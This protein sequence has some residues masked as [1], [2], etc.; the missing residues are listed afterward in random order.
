MNKQKLKK[1]VCQEVDKLEPILIKLAD[2][3]HENPEIS[4]REFKAMQYLQ[5]LLKEFNFLFTPIIK[6][7][8][9]TAFMAQKGIGKKKIGF[10]A[11]YDALPNLGHACGHNL[12]S[13][14]SVG[15]A[16]A[17]N[18]VTDNLAQTILFGCPAEETIGAKLDMAERGYFDDI[19]ACLIIHPDDKTSIG[20]TSYAT[21]PLEISFLG[22]EAHIADPV[23]HGINALDALIDFYGEFKKLEQSFTKRHLIGKIITEGGVAPNI[24]PAR[25][26]M[27]ATIRSTDT[28]YLEKTMLPKIK[29][30]AEIIAKK[31]QTKI[32]LYHYEPLY[33]D[34]RSDKRLEYYYQENFAILGE[35]FT[36]LPDDYADGSTD[37]GNVSHATRTC[38]PTIGIGSNIFAH[39]VE[40]A[41]ASNLP[42]AKKQALLATKA[43]AMTAI[44]VLFEN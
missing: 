14:M 6:D 31:H 11:E 42:F 4:K 30:L 24:I 9:S 8:F 12:I 33:K 38:Q 35:K 15:A 27:R 5:C 2:Y 13:F 19:E 37:V 36:I 1:L 29:N 3:L 21:H 16:L 39:T 20:G 25:A 32:N 17:F 40:F 22:K 44:D 28:N 26:T 34:L 43:M 41:Q 7:K 23:Y 18:A 10:L